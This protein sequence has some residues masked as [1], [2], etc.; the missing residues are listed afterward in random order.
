[1]EP[2]LENFLEKF[3]FANA[4]IIVMHFNVSHSTVQDI[5]SRELGLR[6]FSRRWLR[7]QLS[8]PEKRLRIDTSVEL[9][10]L[11]DQYS[12][13]PFKGIA[14][15]DESSVCHS[16]ESDSMFARRH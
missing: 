7:H 13:L 4:R 16:I 3:L 15:G 5:L 14:T 1:L 10:A 6:K 2:P 11:L 9:F 12:E 8:D